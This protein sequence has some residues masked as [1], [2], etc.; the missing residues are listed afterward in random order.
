MNSFSGKFHIKLNIGKY[1][2][3]T[4]WLNKK[5]GTQ[6]PFLKPKTQKKIVMKKFNNSFLIYSIN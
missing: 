5:R 2:R 3:N 4:I 6:S 1:K